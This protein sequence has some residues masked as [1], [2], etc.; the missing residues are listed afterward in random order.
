[1][2]KIILTLLVAGTITLNAQDA[3]TSMGFAKGNIAVSG[4]LGFES[5][6]HGTSGKHSSLSLSPSVMYMLQDN[7]GVG[8]GLGFKS[9]SDKNAA[10]TTTQ[11]TSSIGFNV[12]GK[13]FFAK[14]QFS[15]YVG[16]GI[17]YDMGSTKNPPSTVE[18]KENT[19]NVN[20]MPGLNYFL[21]NNWAL[22]TEF[23]NLGYS[24][25]TTTVGTAPSTSS[26]DLGIN[27]DMTAWRFG[28]SYIFK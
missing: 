9:G 21:A 20:L 10:G 19:L 15:P 17:G 18:A 13:Y 8:V 16:L 4:G 27:L 22:N 24:S 6:D 1:M 12:G 3:S 25:K 28:I 5:K 11:E 2:K 26:S 14:G 23:G 7:I